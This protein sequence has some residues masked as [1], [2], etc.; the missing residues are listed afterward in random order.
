MM[1]QWQRLERSLRPLS[2][3]LLAALLFIAAQGTGIELFFH[4]SYLLISIVVVAYLWAW[5]NLHGLSVRRETFSHRAQVGDV[6]RERVTLINHWFLPRLWVE[7]LDHSNLPSHGA[8]FVACLPGNE[9]QRWVVRTPCTMRGKFRLGPVTLASSDPLGLFRLQRDIA[10]ATDILVYPRTVPLPEFVLPG[11]ELPGGQ[12]LRR[13]THHVTPNVAALR[14]YQPGDSFNRIHWRSTA[15]LGRLMVKEFE[16]DPTAEV[17]ILLDMN[18]HAQQALRQAEAMP[19]AR[20]QRT[21]ESTEE[22]AVHAAASVARHVLDQNR[23]VGLIAWGQ[24][25]EVIPPEREVRQLYKILEALAELRAYGATS[26]AEVLSAESVRFGRNC[27]LV[28]IT[29]SLDERWV[30]G[31]QHL[32]YRGVRIVAILIDAHSFGGGRSNQTIRMRLAELRVP[33]YV[34]GRGQA[35]AAALA[36]PAPGDQQHVDGMPRRDDLVR[37]HRAG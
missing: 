8:G 7:V 10:G 30:T 23:A 19:V 5:L 28:V 22:Y 20:D 1:M 15:R 9:Q 36:R 32:L 26:L 4:L 29:P 37:P 17:Y 16:L 6:A 24:H 21:A 18:E 27:T 31:V 3:V 13:R 25:R 2:L 33:T 14:E 11:A 12:N 35:L 34:Y